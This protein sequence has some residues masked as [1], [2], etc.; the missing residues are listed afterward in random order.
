MGSIGEDLGVTVH[1]AQGKTYIVKSGDVFVFGKEFCWTL[2]LKYVRLVLLLSHRSPSDRP[3]TT[4][5]VLAMQ[6]L[7]CKAKRHG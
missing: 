5:D 4:T 3:W 2:L 6:Q 1:T 7:S